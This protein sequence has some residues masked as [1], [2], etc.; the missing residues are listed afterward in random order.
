MHQW[1][2]Y[3]QLGTGSGSIRRCCSIRQV[4]S[5]HIRASTSRLAVESLVLPRG[6]VQPA[7]T[8]VVMCGPFR[9]LSD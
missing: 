6:Q 5:W 7:V 9:V 8:G 3:G 4:G 2:I 1:T